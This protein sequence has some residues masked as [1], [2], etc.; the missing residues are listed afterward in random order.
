[1]AG[2]IDWFRWH[3]G[4]VT[5]QK[6]PLI[7]RKAGASVAEVIAVWACLLEAASMN[8][9]LRGHIGGEPDHEAIDCA[10]GLQEGRSMAIYTAM[11]AR[12]LV[13]GCGHISAWPKRQPKREREDDNS[14]HRV[15]AFREKQ[16]QETPSNATERAETPRGEE[17]REEEIKTRAE[18]G[19]VPPSPAP[20]RETL[21]DL[22][23]HEPTP[24]GLLCRAI[25]AAGI[26]DVNPGHADLLRLMA[27]GIAA[28]SFTATAAELVGKGKGKFAL[29]L[30]TV[31]GRWNDAQAAPALAAAAA[32][33]PGVSA[34]A[35]T[36]ALLAQQAEAGRRANSPEAQA[37][38]REA[39]ARLKGVA[40]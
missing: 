38:R 15:K 9:E 11:L 26:Q 37:A 8:A 16:R 18:A 25:K 29:L 17:S 2:G 4:S 6:F 27:G 7:A 23:G 35:Q 22:T 31:E 39:M 30:K 21:P 28:E 13:D 33:A 19:G 32:I 20:V 36:A 24:A 12:G 34:V 40:A 3:H 14:T 10:L 5:D 1:M